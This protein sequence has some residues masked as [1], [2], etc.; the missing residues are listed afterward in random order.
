MISFI[1]SENPVSKIHQLLLGGISPRPICFASTVDKEGNRNLAPFSFFNVFSA[2][3]PIAVFSPAFSGRT[4]EPK[5]TYLNVLEVPEVVINVVTYGMVQQMSLAS[6][7]YPKGVDEFIKT[8]FTP[9]E[10]DIVKPAR[11]KESP[12]QLECKVLEVKSLGTQGGAGNLIICEIVK[13]HIDEKYLNDKG[14]ID[15]TTIDLVAR[16]GENW[17][18]RANSTALFEL[19]KP[20]TTC[21]IGVDILPIHIRQSTQ[22]TGNDLGILGNIETLPTT[23]EIQ[24]IKAK[25]SP[26]E[27]IPTA[28]ELLAQG[29]AVEALGVLW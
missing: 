22:L 5:H 25:Y 10:S 17:Y 2:N 21:G 20:L 14:L 13:I 3:P 16:M 7:P 23:Q 15:Q 8:G 18:C 19:T 29:L 1:P 12:M 4:G 26:A 27:P 9:I 28:K 24:A 11:V 6:S